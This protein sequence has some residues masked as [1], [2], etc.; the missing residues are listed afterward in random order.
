[1]PRPASRLFSLPGGQPSP[2]AL[3]EQARSGQCLACVLHCALSQCLQMIWGVNVSSISLLSVHPPSFRGWE[4]SPAQDGDPASLGRNRPPLTLSLPDQLP[5]GHTTLP[6]SLQL[7]PRFLAHPACPSFK[8]PQAAS[9][10]FF[11]RPS[12]INTS[13]PANPASP[14]PKNFLSY[15]PPL[16]CDC[17]STP[18]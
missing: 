14:L 15:F 7:W 11:P 13:S 4:L 3:G 10:Y 9:S 18:H 2:R 1:M 5:G 6:P 8:G 17:A 16:P 12:N